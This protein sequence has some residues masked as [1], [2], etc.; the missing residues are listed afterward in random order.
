MF[1]IVP[2]IAAALVI[3]GGMLI[4]ICRRERGLYD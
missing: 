3:V 1:I 4:A 2:V